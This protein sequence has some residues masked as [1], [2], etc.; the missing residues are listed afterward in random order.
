M[1]K[2]NIKFNNKKKMKKL[3][4]NQLSKKKIQNLIK[5]INQIQKKKLKT[6]KIE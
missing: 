5:I 1:K 3:K 2:L 6:K 4:K